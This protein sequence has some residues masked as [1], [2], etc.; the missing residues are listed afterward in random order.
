MTNIVYDDAF[1]WNEWTV[2]IIISIGFTLIFL[3]PKKFSSSVTVVNLLYGVVIGLM[4]DHTIAIEPIDFY[5]VGDESKYQFFDLFSY[6]MYAPVGY[7][8]IYLYEQLQLPVKKYWLILYIL[9]WSLVGVC[10]EWLGILTG[11]FHYKN[12][13]NTTYSF[14]I[15]LFVQ[16]SQIWLYHY[17]FKRK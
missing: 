8:Y 6:T 15:Y 12:G 17:L 14:P 11:I 13:Y 1:N 10:V 9:L 2:L 3:L 5:D 4:F 7:L 16:A